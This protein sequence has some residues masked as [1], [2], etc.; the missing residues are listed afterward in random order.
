MKN[1][2]INPR[3]VKMRLAYEIVKFFH[4]EEKAE[5]AQNEFI[6]VFQ[7]KNIPDEMKEII[8]EKN[9][10]A[11]DL[12]MKTKSVSSRSEAK[13]LINQG[14]V[15]INDVKIDDPFQLLEINGDEVLRI[16]KRRFFKLNTN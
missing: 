16:G 9:I 8:V 5:Y 12:V 15:K 13:R 6:K 2:S 1:N 4:N 10:S 7:K 11:I 14:A 3:D